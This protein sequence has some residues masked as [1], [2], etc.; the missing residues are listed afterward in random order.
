MILWT[1]RHP[2]TLS[3]GICVGQLEVPITIPVSQAA[4]NVLQEAPVTPPSIWSSDLPRCQ[5][6]AAA[7]ADRWQISHA[8]DPRLREIS[9]GEWEGKSFDE[10]YSAD[11]KRWLYWCENWTSESTPNG[12]SMI[13]V[14]IR[15]HD[16]LHSFH[17]QENT[18]LIAHAGVV[19]VLRCLLGENRKKAFSYSVPHLIW[20]QHTC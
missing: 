15:V 8:I 10:L 9:M 4:H 5:Q 19:R 12:E 18:L 2:P 3:K 20:Q 7:L 6:L 16:W 13:D 11:T 17:R 1:V 14:E